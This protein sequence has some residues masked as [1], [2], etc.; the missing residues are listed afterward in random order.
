MLVS[1]LQVV[2]EDDG[3]VKLDPELYQ[4]YMQ[5]I[6]EELLADHRMFKAEQRRRKLV[7]GG[8]RTLSIYP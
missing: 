6:Y 7:L 5:I 8:K 4:C 1:P 2:V 3:E